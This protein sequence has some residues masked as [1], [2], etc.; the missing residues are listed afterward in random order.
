[1]IMLSD[2]TGRAWRTSWAGALDREAE[3]MIEARRVMA[4]AERGTVAHVITGQGWACEPAT[5]ETLHDYRRAVAESL[6]AA[7]A[8]GGLLDR[9]AVR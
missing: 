6:A 1:M 9:L 8:D 4:R 7:V 3:A 2:R 5:R